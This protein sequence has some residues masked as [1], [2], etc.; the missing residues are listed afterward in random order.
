MKP[1][2]DKPIRFGGNSESDIARKYHHRMQRLDPF[3][4]VEQYMVF[5]SGEPSTAY[6]WRPGDPE[7]DWKCPLLKELD[8]DES[9]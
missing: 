4:H 9:R 6:L 3:A 5:C 7:P 1:T 2:P 8:R